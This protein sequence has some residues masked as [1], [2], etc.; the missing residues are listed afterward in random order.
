V[1]GG[2]SAA[3]V[4]PLSPDE[5]LDGPAGAMLT[6]LV[7]KRMNVRPEGEPSAEPLRSHVPAARPVRRP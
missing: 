6:A 5:R 1:R 7:V 3:G 4:P 2:G